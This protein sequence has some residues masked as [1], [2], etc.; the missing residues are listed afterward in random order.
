MVRKQQKENL[1]GPITSL[2]Y[3]NLYPM[4]CKINVY[5]YVFVFVCVVSQIFRHVN[6]S[7]NQAGTNLKEFLLLPMLFYVPA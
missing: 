7:N 1:L 2:I 5:I 3:G 4:Y 6:Y